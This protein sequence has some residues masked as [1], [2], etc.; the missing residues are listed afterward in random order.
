MIVDTTHLFRVA[1]D[2]VA[3]SNSVRLQVVAVGCAFA[4]KVG[5]WGPAASLAHRGRAARLEA[6]GAV[7]DAWRRPVCHAESTQGNDCCWVV[8]L[9]DVAR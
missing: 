4:V 9:L 2:T 7:V 3:H 6:V 8:V 1:A 5:P